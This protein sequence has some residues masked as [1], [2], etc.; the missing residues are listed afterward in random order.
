MSSPER[1]FRRRKKAS[2][3][4]GYRDEFFADP[5]L[6]EDDYRRLKLRRQRT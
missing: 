5:R 1:R 6:V 3:S 2:R 4:A